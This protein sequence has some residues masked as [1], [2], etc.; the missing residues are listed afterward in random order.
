M[1]PTTLEPGTF[2]SL[3]RSDTIFGRPSGFRQLFSFPLGAFLEP[4]GWL[5]AVSH[6]PSTRGTGSNPSHEQR[7]MA[8]IVA[9]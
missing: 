7:R 8:E 1:F 4:G 6:L 3:C 2:G 9:L 5:G